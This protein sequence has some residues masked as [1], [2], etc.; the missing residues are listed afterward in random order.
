M[1]A[2]PAAAR[3]RLL[4]DQDV[5]DLAAAAA[6]PPLSGDDAMR[7]RAAMHALLATH[8]P[9]PLRTLEFIEQLRNA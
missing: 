5:P 1:R 2:L 7:A 6:L 9:G 8:L 4:E 3:R